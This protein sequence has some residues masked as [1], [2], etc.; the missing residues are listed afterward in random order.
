MLPDWDVVRSSWPLIIG[1]AVVWA[2]LEVALSGTKRQSEANAG[3]LAKLESKVDAQDKTT[4]GQ[5]VI[6]ATIVAQTTAMKETL[7]R[8]ARK[9]EG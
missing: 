6:L 2:R 1:G 8:V 4:Q 5:A 3:E 9:L 7:D